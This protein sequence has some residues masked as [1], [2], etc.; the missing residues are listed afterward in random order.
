MLV[1]DR[2][3][4]GC[5]I[6]SLTKGSEKRVKL[7]CDECGRLSETSWANYKNKQNKKSNTQGYT[8]CRPCSCAKNAFLRRGKTSPLK[9]K[10]FP[11]KRKER[12]ISW[13]GGRYVSS[14]G[15]WVVYVSSKEYK[16]EHILIME[17]SL[18]RKMEIGEQVHHID[19]NKLNNNLENLY[20]V[21]NNS[22]H[23]K[24]HQQLQRFAFSM[25]ESG[26]IKFDREKGEYWYYG[27]I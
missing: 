18:G 5:L 25:V 3:I 11:T 24:L 16:K 4:D 1:S 2:T 13:K 17:E 9:G 12:H 7:Q 26:D 21:K 22:E 27:N 8:I 23:K 19:G 6:D 20:V 15:Y 14:D 10:I